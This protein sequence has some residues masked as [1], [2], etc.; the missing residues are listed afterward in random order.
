VLPRAILALVAVVAIG[1]A[2]LVAIVLVWPGPAV[3]LM[4]RWGTPEFSGSCER[5]EAKG[6]PLDLH[7]PPPRSPH[8][9][10][11]KE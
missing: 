4:R 11:A 1:L 3:Q 10:R 5:V 9:S 7:R 2:A 6:A 8:P